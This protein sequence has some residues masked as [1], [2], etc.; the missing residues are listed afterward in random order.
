MPLLGVMVFVALVANPDLHNTSNG[1]LLRQVTQIDWIGCI[2]H[3]GCWVLFCLGTST[4]G[5]TWAWNSAAAITAW[6]LSGV[7][8]VT[9]L[10][11]QT[12]SV[13]TSREHRF[14]PAHILKNR[15]ILLICL[16]ISGLAPSYGVSIYYLP[17]YYAFTLG[18]DPLETA[19]RLLAPIGGFIVSVIL[20][21]A[22]LPRVRRYKPF[23]L[24]A[25]TLT[26]AASGPLTIIDSHFSETA[27]IVLSALL[28][29]GVG[30]VWMI[31]L[32]IITLLVPAE[33]VQ[34]AA[35][36]ASIVQVA[37]STMA[38]AVCACLF[39]NVGFHKIRTVIDQMDVPDI[40]DDK[41][42]EALAGVAFPDVL[43]NNA[44]VLAA[45]AGA[46]AE[47]VGT[48]YYVALAGSVF[49][50]LVSLLLKW[51]ALDFGDKPTGNEQDQSQ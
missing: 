49:S 46:L 6:V 18:Y 33:D 7:L 1:P 43:E 17:L 14:I 15:T 8:I 37:P 30:L 48:L 21:G 39:K 42:H 27:I 10:L 38:L 36:V 50:L 29:I 9:F 4:S 24:I 3:A 12:F 40:T 13:F 20:T 34:H 44:T 2:L 19:L 26:L 28:G 41:I 25:S 35:T 23:F 11:Q 22:L 16:G 45:T 5:S 32:G 47:T 31:G 51:D